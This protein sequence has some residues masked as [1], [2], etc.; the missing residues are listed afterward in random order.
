MIKKETFCDPLAALEKGVRY[1]QN[2]NAMALGDDKIN[3]F[4]FIAAAMHDWSLSTKEGGKNWG[5]CEVCPWLVRA[6]LIWQSPVLGHDM[7]DLTVL[8]TLLS[9]LK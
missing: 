1:N 2:K 8:D 4:S 7:A 3:A 9:D 5:Q 6:D